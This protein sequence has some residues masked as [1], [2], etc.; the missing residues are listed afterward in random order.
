MYGIISLLGVASMEV[1]PENLSGTAHSLATLGGNVGRVI[2]GYPLSVVATWMSWHE[3]FLAVLLVSIASLGV[4]IVCVQVLQ[5]RDD[6]KKESK[7]SV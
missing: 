4:S 2:A 6:V 7:R 1:A 3:S 5:S